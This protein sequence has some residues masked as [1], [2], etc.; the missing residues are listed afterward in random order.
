[1][2]RAGG[3]DLGAVA[4]E[5][6]AAA[7]AQAISV[8]GATVS[9]GEEP[10]DQTIALD[11]DTGGARGR[12]H[13]GEVGGEAATHPFLAEQ[14]VL[15]EVGG[16]APVAVLVEEVARAVE[17][18]IFVASGLEQGAWLLVDLQRALAGQPGQDVVA[19]IAGFQAVAQVVKAGLAQLRVPF[20][21]LLELVLN[22]AR[23]QTGGPPAGAAGEDLEG[24][25][26]VL[27]IDVGQLQR[28]GT[29]GAQASLSG[30]TG[31]SVVALQ[32]GG[33]FGDL[34][35]GQLEEGHLE[36]G[37]GGDG[38]GLPGD[39]IGHVVLAVATTGLV[40]VKA[41]VLAS[42]EFGVGVELQGHLAQAGVGV[43][44]HAPAVGVAQDSVVELK[45][46][47]AGVAGDSVSAQ[48]HDA[49]SV[50]GQLG[51][52]LGGKDLALAEE[53]PVV[54]DLGCFVARRELI[55]EAL[56]LVSHELEIVLAQGQNVLPHLLTL[57]V[58][59]DQDAGQGQGGQSEGRFEAAGR[60]Q[61]SH[62]HDFRVAGR[63]HS[64]GLKC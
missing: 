43:T 55:L 62:V 12:G 25:A 38:D 2:D 36:E 54:E 48:A 63:V 30:A 32:E 56:G 11:F 47:V 17:R 8:D 7:Q 50:D 4:H 52:S 35:V 18:Q 3:T 60:L 58:V 31:S 51:G 41:G 46:T 59:P 27:E 42:V 61:E 5:L 53:Q 57:L 29:E 1:M 24:Q 15:V 16:A 13:R 9:V 34:R 23:G 64:L 44:Q 10:A 37:W 45:A 19:A 6:W 26:V 20:Q 33:G 39:R 21:A 28:L 40:E 49:Q 14:V 22:G